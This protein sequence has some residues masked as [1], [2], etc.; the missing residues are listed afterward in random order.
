MT[1][2]SSVFSIANHT[3]AKSKRR[4]FVHLVK[5]SQASCALDLQM[6]KESTLRATFAW[7]CNGEYHVSP[8][9]SEVA[10]DT[11]SGIGSN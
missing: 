1:Q 4:C 11:K 7:I 10:S 8:L 5:D 3:L 6:D 2:V 9:D